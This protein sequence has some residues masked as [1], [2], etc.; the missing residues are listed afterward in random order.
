MVPYRKNYRETPTG[1]LRY[2]SQETTASSNKRI[3][4]QELEIR[5]Y[6]FL[7][8]YGLDVTRT[9]DGYYNRNT[10]RY[11]ST[12]DGGKD[13]IA[14]Y[15]EKN[16]L[17]QCK[18]HEAEIGSPIIRQLIGCMNN[19]HDY[20]I[21]VAKGFNSGAKRI[22]ESSKEKIVLATIETLGT[23]LTKLLN[24]QVMEQEEEITIKNPEGNIHINFST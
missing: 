6:E 8:N 3:K 4:G 17:V 1:T 22:A 23:E 20:G 16:I 5:T 15:K 10:Q 13:M 2:R 12:G 14:R 18:N 24:N 9:C 7:K 19:K 21:I 11:I